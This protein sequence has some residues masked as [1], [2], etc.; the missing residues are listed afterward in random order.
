MSIQ[1]NLGIKLQLYFNVLKTI[2]QPFKINPQPYFIKQHFINGILLSTTSATA[3]MRCR[4]PGVSVRRLHSH[5]PL[6]LRDNHPTPLGGESRGGFSG[7]CAPGSGIFPGPY[8]PS[9]HPVHSGCLPVFSAALPVPPQTSA[10][11][12][13]SAEARAPHILRRWRGSA[14]ILLW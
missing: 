1:N 4:L 6:S 2:L 10:K 11:P 9:R 14:G 5:S 7:H 13:T 12:L 8:H 3:R